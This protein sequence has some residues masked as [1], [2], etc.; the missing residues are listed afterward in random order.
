MLDACEPDEILFYGKVPPDTA[1][2]LRERGI[3]WQAF[4]HRMAERL[5][6]AAFWDS[7]SEEAERCPKEEQAT[8]VPK[9]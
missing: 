1:A 3:Q 6:G 5:R 2:L 4:P 8:A 9:A 7:D